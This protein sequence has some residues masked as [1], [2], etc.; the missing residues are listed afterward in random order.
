M[1]NGT[2]AKESRERKEKKKRKTLHF[3]FFGFQGGKELGLLIGEEA[4]EK[5]SP[6]FFSSE[7]WRISEPAFTKV[8]KTNESPLRPPLV[9]VAF[10]KGRPP[11]SPRGRIII[12]VASYSAGREG[13][14]EKEENGDFGPGKGGG[15]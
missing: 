4:A 2:D 14:G 13:G 9:V 10:I 12:K 5:H 8:F 6:L 3:L 11:L 1:I 15:R 7:K